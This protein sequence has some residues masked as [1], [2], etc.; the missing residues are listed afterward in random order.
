[1][2]VYYD[3]YPAIAFIAKKIRD[4]EYSPFNKNIEP[5]IS[6]ITFEEALHVLFSKESYRE[7][8]YP[9]KSKEEAYITFVQD[10][11][12]TYKIIDEINSHKMI[13]QLLDVINKLNTE[14]GYIEKINVRSKFP[15]F[16]DLIHFILADEV[17]DIFITTDKGFEKLERIKTKKLSKIIILDEES[18][19]IEKEIIFYI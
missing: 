12:S 4:H 15:G 9:E 8:W 18:L 16:I 10:L 13:M 7:K 14:Y 19:S 1:M 11:L 3:T 5:F 17:C 2:K 6:L